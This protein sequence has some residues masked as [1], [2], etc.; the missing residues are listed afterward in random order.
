MS[1]KMYSQI[2]TYPKA[3]LFVEV[4][5]CPYTV[6]SV[7]RVHLLAWWTEKAEGQTGASGHKLRRILIYDMGRGECVPQFSLQYFSYY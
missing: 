2:I 6:H 3:E 4:A 5:L 1:W 7:L